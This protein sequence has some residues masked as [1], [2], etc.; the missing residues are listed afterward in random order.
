[1]RIITR[2]IWILSLV[3]LFTDVASEMLYPIMP[4]YLESIQYSVLFIGILEGIAEATAGFS[5]G[6]FGKLSDATGKRLPFVRIGY[7][8]SA[9]SKPMM[10]VFTNAAWILTARTAD[11]LGKGIRT[12]ARDALLS[13]EATKE[14]KATVFGFHRSLDTFGAVLGPLAA[15]VF[16]YF[17]PGKYTWLFYIAFIPGI[18]AIGCTYLL[19][20]KKTIGNKTINRPSFFSFIRYWKD[21]TTAYKKLV[22]GLLI[23]A[24]FNSSDVF[25]L[26]KL[27]AG[28]LDDTIVIGMYIFYNL[29]YALSAYPAGKLADKLG[30]KGVFITGLCLFV[31]VYIGMAMVTDWYIYGILFAIYGLYAALT[32]G[33][34][35]AWVTNECSA[36]YTATAVGAYTSFQSIATM[37]A[38]SS[39][40]LL[41]VY[42]GAG[43]TFWVAA[44]GTI[45]TVVYFIS[46]VKNSTA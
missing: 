42:F 11:R 6:Y 36:D 7:G 16:L 24:L 35:K 19:K 13:A 32:E 40:G 38:S 46:G 2:T 9:L 10:A 28:G 30:L 27:R 14:T 8:L 20:D 39:A 18:L 34:A 29:I 21:S 26:L 33:V 41:W 17:Y 4:L 31:I 45:I 22:I 43:T 23:F 25:L 37:L 15:L 44:A 12:G 3:S 5:K 1:M